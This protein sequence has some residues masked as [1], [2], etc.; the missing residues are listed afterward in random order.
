MHGEGPLWCWCWNSGSDTHLLDGRNERESLNDVIPF[1]GPELTHG[2]AESVYS[3]PFSTRLLLLDTFVGRTIKELR[4]KMVRGSLRSLSCS[5][6]ACTV[7]SSPSL[8]SLPT[9]LTPNQ[10]LE[11]KNHHISK[12]RHWNL[13][14]QRVPERHLTFYFFPGHHTSAHLHTWLSPGQGVCVVVHCVAVLSGT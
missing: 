5:I 13:P 14:E 2:L 4:S 8:D 7:L 6:T 11:G 9:M 10:P 3:K 1:Q 12:R